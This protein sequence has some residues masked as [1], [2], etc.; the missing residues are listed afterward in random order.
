MNNVQAKIDLNQALQAAVSEFRVRYEPLLRVACEVPEGVAVNLDH[1]ALCSFLGHALNDIRTQQ[2]RAHA[3]LLVQTI[4]DQHD[5]VQA[6][7]E[8]HRG[9]LQ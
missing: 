8:Q 7:I 6:A 4:L 3:E 1:V 9:R 2:G 5:Q